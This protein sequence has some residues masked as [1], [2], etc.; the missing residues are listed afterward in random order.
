[1]QVM[2]LYASYASYAK[3]KCTKYRQRIK[4]LPF[5]RLPLEQVEHGT[6]GDGA[7]K[8]SS[9]T[10]GLICPTGWRRKLPPGIP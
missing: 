2:Q 6:G 5:Q 3:Q 1:M 9:M 4:K 7:T 10:K 8:T